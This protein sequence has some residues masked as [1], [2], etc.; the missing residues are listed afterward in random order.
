MAMM[1]FLIAVLGE[2]GTAEGVVVGLLGAW[3]LATLADA[4]QIR[5]TE[6][7]EGRH[8]Y[9][10]VRRPTAVGRHLVYEAEPA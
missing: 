10:A 7:S 9:A 5:H 3:G 6:R 4:H 8:Y 1:I 2:G